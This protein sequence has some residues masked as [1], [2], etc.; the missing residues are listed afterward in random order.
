MAGRVVLMIDESKCTACRGC[1]VACKQWNDNGYEETTNTGTYENPPDLNPDTFTRIQFFEKLEEGQTKF[2]FLKQGCM[3]CGNAACVTV[4]PTKALK[5][6]EMGFVSVEKDLCNGCGYCAEFC[7]FNIPRIKVDSLI[8]GYGK[9]SKCHLCQDRITNGL[10]PACAKTCPPGAIKYGD[11]DELIADAK[12]RI[13][14]L[15]N[16][17]HVNASLYGENVLDGLGRMYILTE[18]PE[19]YGL[20]KE[21]RLPVLTEFWQSI[22]QPAGGYIFG[23]GILG[24]IINYLVASQN[25]KKVSEES[26]GES[27]TEGREV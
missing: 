21:P 9:T 1:Q 5:Q 27:T 26:S 6:H 14:I 25:V 18:K 20:P 11:R 17:G 24:L 16:Q 10:T 7:P 2:F 3:H 12:K 4:C 13:D 15:K 8:T 22:L 19:E 23:L